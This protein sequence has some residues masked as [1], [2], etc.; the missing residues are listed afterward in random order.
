[1]EWGCCADGSKGVAEYGF[2]SFRLE[3]VL[4]WPRIS[5]NRSAS[6]ESIGVMWRAI[7]GFPDNAIMKQGMEKQSLSSAC[8]D[9]ECSRT[10]LF[11]ETVPAA[12]K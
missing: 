9:I 10:E 12:P 8:C 3:V 6:A 2:L 7:L 4:F 5:G 11:R 1:M